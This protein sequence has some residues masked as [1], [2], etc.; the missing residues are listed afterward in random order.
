MMPNHRVDR[1]GAG[2]CRFATGVES[3]ERRR[4]DIAWASAAVGH[5][6]RSAN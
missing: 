4:D 3:L 5:S 2:P 1:T 6:G